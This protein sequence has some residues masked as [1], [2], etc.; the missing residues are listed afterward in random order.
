MAYHYRFSCSQF[1][2][3]ARRTYRPI[4]ISI[5]LVALPT[6]RR[7]LALYLPFRKSALFRLLT[8]DVS[9]DGQALTSPDACLRSARHCCNLPHS[10]AY[11][12]MFRVLNLKFKV[13]FS[14]FPPTFRELYLRPVTAD[15]DLHTLF[16]F[17]PLPFQATGP[18]SPF[19]IT[20]TNSFA[21]T[22]KVR[23]SLISCVLCF[24]L[25]YSPW[26]AVQ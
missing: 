9:T 5:D 12:P 1:F 8:L 15:V 19:P 17:V 23:R 22:S 25:P 11:P 13:H 3:S 21:R 6:I 7:C 18:S 10:L 26:S 14:C 20:D 24:H 4:S 16:P 2:S